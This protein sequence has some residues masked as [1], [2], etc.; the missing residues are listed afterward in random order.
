MMHAAGGEKNQPLTHPLTTEVS[1]MRLSNALLILF[2]LVAANGC[3]TIIHGTTQDISVT[4]DPADADL[5]VDGNLRYKSPA[6]IA[7]KRKDDH[8]VEISRAGY[9]SEKIDIKGTISAAVLGDFLAG[10]A[11]GYG[12]DAA[13][14]AQRRLEPEKVEVR[15]QPLSPQ[16]MSAAGKISQDE[17]LQQ[18]KTLKDE[19]KIT[20]EQYNQVRQEIVAAPGKEKIAPPAPPKQ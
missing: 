7:M 5:L 10:G 6:T 17:K 14:G 20:Q 8:T 3:A 16:E 18:L 15:L 12:I 13:T 11:I 4:T 19:G 9:K 2:L 1:V